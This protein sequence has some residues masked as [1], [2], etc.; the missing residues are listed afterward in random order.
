MK[1][2]MSWVIMGGLLAMVSAMFE[3]DA[4]KAMSEKIETSMDTERSHSIL[5]EFNPDPK[6]MKKYSFRASEGGAFIKGERLTFSF[7]EPISVPKA[8]AKP[9][10]NARVAALRQDSLNV[11]QRKT[12]ASGLQCPDKKD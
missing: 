4:N 10:L 12:A 9:L 7:G 8:P 6:T 3:K 2:F 11:P 5:L 1:M